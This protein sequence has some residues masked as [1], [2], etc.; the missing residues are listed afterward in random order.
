MIQVLKKIALLLPA[1]ALVCTV[2]P[3]SPSWAEEASVPTVVEAATETVEE[4]LDE[5]ETA[6]PEIAE[7]EVAA[8]VEEAPAKEPEKA[9]LSSAPAGLT[10][11]VYIVPLGKEMNLKVIYDYPMDFESDKHIKSIQMEKE[12]ETFLGLKQFHAKSKKPYAEFLVNPELADFT[13]VVLVADTPT[14]GKVKTLVKLEFTPEDELPD[15]YNPKV[16]RQKALEE[17]RKAKE[18]GLSQASTNSKK[19]AEVQKKVESKKEEIVEEAEENE[20]SA[21]KEKKKKFGLF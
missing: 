8:P 14:Y 5:A 2:V 19:V 3:F 1:F 15:E 21:E 10:P 6:V 9:P 20:E 17:A 12:D 13:Q 16:L 4:V 7:E 18:A 11:Q